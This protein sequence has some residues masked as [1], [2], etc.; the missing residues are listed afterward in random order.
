MAHAIE[1]LGWQRLTRGIVLTAP[2][3]PSRADWAQVGLAIGGSGAALSGWDA[4]R[5]ALVG[6]DRPPPGADV[7]VLSRAVPIIDGTDRVIAVADLLWRALRA[8]IEIDSREFHF[9]EA[10]WKTTMTRHN[11]LTA[12]GYAVTHYPPSY[13]RQRGPALGSRGGDVA[14]H[15]GSRTRQTL[16]R[17]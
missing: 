2:G 13:V 11:E 14:G 10:G 3:Q 6:S 16:S 5:L 8:I 1:R 7:L 4:V 12:L 9:D 15:P 17:A